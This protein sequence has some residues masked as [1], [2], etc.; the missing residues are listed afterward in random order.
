MIGNGV[1][2]MEEVFR[3]KAMLTY[4]GKKGFFGNELKETYE[5]SCTIDP[6]SPSC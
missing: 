3:E 5:S 4:F 2:I 1:I 6:E